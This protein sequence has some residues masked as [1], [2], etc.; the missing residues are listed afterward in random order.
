M[1]VVLVLLFIA[2]P[3]AELYVIVQVGQGIGFVN[4]IGLL[5]LISVLGAWLAKREGLGV[6]RRIRQQLDA[7][8]APAAEVLDGFLVLLAAALLLVPGFLTDIVAIVLLLPPLR[9]VVRKVAGRRFTSSVEV[10]RGS[11]DPSR[12]PDIDVE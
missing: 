9:A 7:G 6:V 12:P 1:F 11:V 2:V 4:T 10:F 5:I 8:R 3:I